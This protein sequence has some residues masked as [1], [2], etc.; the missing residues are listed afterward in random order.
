M[1]QPPDSPDCVRAAWG[2]GLNIPLAGG[3][4]RAQLVCG[5][6]SWALA[7]RSGMAVIT[8]TLAKRLP[9]PAAILGE[10]ECWL[11]PDK[12]QPICIQFIRDQ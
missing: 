3:A 1:M 2:E 9:R 4:M 5:D 11:T 10:T 12:G 6:R 8:A 7:V